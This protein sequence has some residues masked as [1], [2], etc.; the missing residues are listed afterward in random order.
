MGLFPIY[1]TLGCRVGGISNFYFFLFNSLRDL[2]PLLLCGLTFV[3]NAARMKTHRYLLLWLRIIICFV[4]GIYININP[5]WDLV[6]KAIVTPRFYFALIA[7]FG[8]CY[9]ML[10][11]IHVNNKFLNRHY[12]WQHNAYLRTLLQLIGGV[13]VPIIVDW[14]L[15][16]LY[17]FALGIQDRMPVYFMYYIL[18]VIL[19]V[20]GI[21]V[22]YLIVDLILN[23]PD[24]NIF[25]KQ[26][27]LEI[28]HNGADLVLNIQSDILYIYKD[29]K[30]I[31]VM[32]ISGHEYTKKDTIRNI[33]KTYPN[34]SLC[35]INQSTIVNLE[36]LKGQQNGT[37]SK[38]IDLLFKPQYHD[39]IIKSKFEKLYVTREFIISF[40]K[41][42]GGIG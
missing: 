35:Q 2:T 30:N 11:I 8:I 19:F 1:E 3:Q 10:Y 25:R 12:P 29:V 9:L 27:E 7:S 42:Y 14:I 17:L 26:Y 13:A 41:K 6:S 4:S 39:V 40:R 32:T 23:V 5:R 28:K 15:V 16:Y 22:V 37:R 21:N 36:M 38:T 34:S 24:R 18:T 31:K 20:L 33:I